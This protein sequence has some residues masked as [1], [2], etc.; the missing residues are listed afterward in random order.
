MEWQIGQLVQF[1]DSKTWQLVQFI[2]QLVGLFIPLAEWNGPPQIEIEIDFLGVNGFFRST[3]SPIQ[4]TNIS[5][6][7]AR[8][9]QC[10]YD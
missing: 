2:W 8:A 7:G 1:I 4:R 3:A 10:G 6:P 5:A 9:S